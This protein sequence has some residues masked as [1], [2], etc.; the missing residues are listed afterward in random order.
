MFYFRPTD[1]RVLFFLH[2]LDYAFDPGRP[3]ESNDVLR[4][5]LQTPTWAHAFYGY[6]YEFLQTSFNRPYMTAWASHYAKLLP[7][8]AW[9][10]WLD[11][12][13]ARQGQVMG[14]LMAKAGAPIPFEVTSPSAGV[15]SLA[16]PVRGR[17]WI[18]VRE[19]RIV[20]TGQALDVTWSNLTAWETRLP[21]DLAPG[22]HTLGAYGGAGELLGT[23]IVTLLSGQ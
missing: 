7:E 15:V 11:Y 16:T 1:E 2:D 19:I 20:E 14:Q 10:G 6:V 12:I 18:D 8:Q 17:G 3:L 4:K 23:S 21:A 13:D 22:P 5:L 9:A